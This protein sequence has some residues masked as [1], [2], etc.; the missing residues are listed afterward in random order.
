MSST[1]ACKVK[2]EAGAH[3]PSSFLAAASL[4]SHGTALAVENTFI[5]ILY[6]SIQAHG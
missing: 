3:M 5:C 6:V 2:T 1:A 4:P